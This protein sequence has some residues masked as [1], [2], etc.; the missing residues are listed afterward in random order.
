MSELVPIGAVP[1]FV[2]FPVVNKEL[3]EINDEDKSDIIEE[4]IDRK[5]FDQDKLNLNVSR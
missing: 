3:D 4:K 5:L 1:C 2:K